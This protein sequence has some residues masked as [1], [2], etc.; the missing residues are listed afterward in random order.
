M[1]DFTVKDFEGAGQ[2]LVRATKDFIENTGYLTTIMY[3]VGYMHGEGRKGQ[4]TLLISM[5]DGWSN[6]RTYITKDA[7][8]KKLTDTEDWI[9][10]IWR[11]DKKANPPVTGKQLFV[12]YLNIHAEQEYR[13]ATQEEIVRVVASQNWRWKGLYHDKNFDYNVKST[14]KEKKDDK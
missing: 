11:T 1:R 4:K 7:E 2:Y 6:D 8:G 3:K 12:D 14:I 10:I 13:F 9:K 5:A